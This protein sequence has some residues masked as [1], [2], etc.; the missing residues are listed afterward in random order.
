LWVGPDWFAEARGE[1][2]TRSLLLLDDDPDFR[3]Y[4][5]AALKNEKVGLLETG[6]P[7]A[8]RRILKEEGEQVGLLLVDGILPGTSGVE[9]V[10]R[11]RADGYQGAIFFLSA[12]LSAG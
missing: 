3:S 10:E 9:L 8:A 1:E 4:L 12:F 6:D 7:E 5:A 2:M 11:V